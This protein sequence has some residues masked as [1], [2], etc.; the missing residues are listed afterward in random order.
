MVF[1][2]QT[3]DDEGCRIVEFGTV[4]LFC[5]FT[6]IVD[7]IKLR[8]FLFLFHFVVF[9][10]TK[11]SFQHIAANL[12]IFLFVVG[13]MYHIHIAISTLPPSNTFKIQKLVIQKL[14]SDGHK[15]HLRQWYIFKTSGRRAAQTSE[16][17]NP[18]P[19]PSKYHHGHN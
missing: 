18:C 11:F 12:R 2:M 1:E 8:V 15:I 7:K 16:W 3:S 9:V 10:F 17:D 6:N 14:T 5:F 4:P 19:L 13:G